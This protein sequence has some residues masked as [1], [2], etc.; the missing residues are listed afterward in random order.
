M[1][2]PKQSI[3]PK[4]VNGA[5]VAETKHKFISRFELLNQK[6]LLSQIK[7]EISAL[8]GYVVDYESCGSFEWARSAKSSIRKLKSE[9]KC[10][11]REIET[12]FSQD[13]LPEVDTNDFY[14]YY[15]SAEGVD[16]YLHS[17]NWKCLL[18]DYGI[19]DLPPEITGKVVEVDAFTMNSYLRRRFRHLNHLP[20]GRTFFI[21]EVELE[22]PVI[23]E[24]TLTKFS[25]V[26][27]RRV[28][29][30]LEHE[31]LELK[32]SI[33]KEI[34]ENSYPLLPQESR[35]VGHVKLEP[36]SFTDDDFVPL[37]IAVSRTSPIQQNSSST[38]LIAPCTSQRSFASVSAAGASAI[39]DKHRVANFTKLNSSSNTNMRPPSSASSWFD[40]VTT[41]SNPDFEFPPFQSSRGSPPESMP[42]NNQRKSRRNKRRNEC[43]KD[44]MEDTEPPD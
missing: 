6:E 41:T 24:A 38:S 12:T 43:A 34:V 17:I 39:V 37:E 14:V 20:I 1:R 21:V 15:Q 31:E 5:R 33:E 32:L 40:F 42:A 3:F 7:E 30:R 44:P 18:E 13:V 28:Q 27:A 10:L 23:T 4:I 8:E 2:R 22:S 16:V 11:L 35:I 26:I 25:D 29:K 36:T 9:E 19:S